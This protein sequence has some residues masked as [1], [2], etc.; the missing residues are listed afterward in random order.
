MQAFGLP[1]AQV[2]GDPRTANALISEL[3]VFQIAEAPVLV[4]GDTFAPD[5][6]APRR[7]LERWPDADCPGDEPG[8]NP[9]GVWRLGPHGG[10]SDPRGTQRPVFIPALVAIL[11]AA[12]EQAGRPLGREEVE[13]L[14]EGGAC[15]TMSHG[16]AQ[17]LERS[18]GYADLE[19]TLA[20][21]QWQVARTTLA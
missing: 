4:T 11:T 16:D 18:R 15:I 20:W 17:Q 8:H 10:R 5:A 21:P 3:N 9:F 2:A 6:D 1:D 12:E 13:R 19:P 14:T 7:R